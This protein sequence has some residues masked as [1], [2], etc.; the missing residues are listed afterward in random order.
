MTQAVPNTARGLQKFYSARSRIGGETEPLTPPS[1]PPGENAADGGVGNAGVSYVYLSNKFDY[2]S[3]KL[4]TV[5]YSFFLSRS[6]F[7]M[8]TRRQ[9]PREDRRIRCKLE[10]TTGALLISV[11]RSSKVST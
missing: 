4:K 1:S 9:A 8:K 5:L 11:S 3:S 6:T 7:V 10:T 2:V